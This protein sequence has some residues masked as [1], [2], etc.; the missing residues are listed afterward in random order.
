MYT[1]QPL[2]GAAASYGT[3]VKQGA[4]IAIKEINGAG[5]VK[6]GDK[7]YQFKLEFA[8]DEASEDK[9]PQ[10]YNS[11]MDKGINAVLGLSLIH[12]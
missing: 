10:A 5:G 12:I 4:E 2:T 7:T 6:V 1:R 3:S 8:D 11:L 9:A